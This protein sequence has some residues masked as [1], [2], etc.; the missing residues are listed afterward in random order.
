MYAFYFYVPIRGA[1]FSPKA[2]PEHRTVTHDICWARHRA[3]PTSF[4]H[5]AKP[6]SQCIMHCDRLSRARH[7]GPALLVW[8]MQKARPGLNFGPGRPGR[9]PL[10]FASLGPM[11]LLR[12]SQFIAYLVFIRNNFCVTTLLECHF[13]NQYVKSCGDCRRVSV[14]NFDYRLI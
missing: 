2:K 11:H 10:E 1:K 7:I 3:R 5:C 4:K 14:V 13:A 8:A 12:G 6:G 9:W